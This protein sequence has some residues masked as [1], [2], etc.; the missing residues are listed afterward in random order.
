MYYI[1]LSKFKSHLTFEV[2]K[3]SENLINIRQK[4]VFIISKNKFLMNLIIF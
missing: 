3:S 4:V 1:C 2:R